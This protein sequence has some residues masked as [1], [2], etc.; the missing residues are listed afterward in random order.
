MWHKDSDHIIHV[1]CGP[2]LKTKLQNGTKQNSKLYVSNDGQRVLLVTVCS[3]GSAINLWQFTEKI[4]D[5]CNSGKRQ[6]ELPGA[7]WCFDT[8]NQVFALQPTIS[9]KDLALDASFI[10]DLVLGNRFLCG[11]AYTLDSC[12]HI[13]NLNIRWLANSNVPV[14][15]WQEIKCPLTRLA[16]DA[17]PTQRK[18]AHVLRWSHDGRVLALAT[19]QESGEFDNIVFLSPHCDI[20]LVANFPKE[21]CI[22]RHHRWVCDMTWTH[23]DLFIVTINNL[24][25]ICL[26]SRLGE[27]LTISTKG[28]SVDLSAAKAL[29]IHPFIYVR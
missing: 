10:V 19:N 21:N 27:P 26:L 1:D 3:S 15:Y 16:S 5:A 11:L 12:V 24:G 14:H 13:L 20:L 29:N 4:E 23:D 6:T 28:C 18:G 17:Q 9:N 7:W 25:S 8:M 2:S 22:R